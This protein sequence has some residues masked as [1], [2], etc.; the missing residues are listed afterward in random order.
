MKYHD[1]RELHF[2]TYI[3]SRHCNRVSI[4]GVY[5]LPFFPFTLYVTDNTRDC[6]K[7]QL[8]AAF[9]FE[10]QE[11]VFNFRGQTEEGRGEKWIIVRLGL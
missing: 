11:M 8:I 2:C 9:F 3:P 5:V 10:T 6:A 4:D 1:E 7:K